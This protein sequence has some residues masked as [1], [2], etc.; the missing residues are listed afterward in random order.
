MANT[1]QQLMAV[2]GLEPLFRKPRTTTAAS[3]TRVYPYLLHD[4]VLTH[5][6]EVWGSDITYVPMRHSFMYLT[7]VID[8][9]SRCVGLSRRLQALR[10]PGWRPCPRN[11]LA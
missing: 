8:R 3:G 6:D 11:G 2:M 9:F 7:A 4:R 5:A 1:L 10:L